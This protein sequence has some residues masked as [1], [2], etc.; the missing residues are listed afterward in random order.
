[1]VFTSVNSDCITAPERTLRVFR[2]CPQ[3][4]GR[5]SCCLRLVVFFRAERMLAFVVALSW[6]VRA[7]LL[8]P[9][10]ASVLSLAG[11][12]ITLYIPVT[13]VEEKRNIR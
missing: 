4:R 13:V 6:V 5:L 12:L 7:F 10:M 3:L 11:S 9:E 8:T 2:S 1:M